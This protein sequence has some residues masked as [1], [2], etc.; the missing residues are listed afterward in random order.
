MSAVKERI[1]GAV[2]V[3]SEADAKRVWNV[4]RMQLGIDEDIPTIKEKKII[5]AY[6]QGDEEYQPYIS[7]DELKRELGLGQN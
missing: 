2:T 3:M 5:E 1:L 4:I 7:H 6:K